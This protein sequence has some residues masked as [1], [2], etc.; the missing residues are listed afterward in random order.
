MEHRY[1]VITPHDLHKKIIDKAY[2]GIIVDVRETDELRYDGKIKGIVNI[3]FSLFDLLY[4]DYLPDKSSEIVLFCAHAPRAAYCADI[5]IRVGYT[6]VSMVMGGFEE[7][8]A[9]YL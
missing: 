8:K 9:F 1:S 5:L 2:D 6:D 4:E 7:Y 3:P